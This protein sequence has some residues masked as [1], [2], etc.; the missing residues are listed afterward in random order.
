MAS[1]CDSYICVRVR[2]C[3]IHWHRYVIL[4]YLCE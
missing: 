2:P 3:L 1:M 4:I